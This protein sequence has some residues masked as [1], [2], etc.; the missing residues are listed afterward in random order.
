MQKQPSI[1]AQKIMLY[2]FCRNVSKLFHGC[3]SKIIQ[4]KKKRLATSLR[5]SFHHRGFLV[6]TSRI[7]RAFSEMFNASSVLVKL[8]TVHHRST[9]LL[10]MLL[11]CRLFS[12]NFLFMAAS[13]WNIFVKAPEVKSI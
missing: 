1:S 13:F 6:N 3:L 9:T 2:W 5:R 7:F 8:W 12:Q 4:I 10:K 11:Y